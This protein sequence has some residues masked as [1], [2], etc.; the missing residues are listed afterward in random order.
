MIR[1]RCGFIFNCTYLLRMVIW[2]CRSGIHIPLS[3]DRIYHYDY[4][5]D[6]IAGKIAVGNL[7]LSW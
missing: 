4:D 7:W 5:I 6:D 3:S 1:L 2:V